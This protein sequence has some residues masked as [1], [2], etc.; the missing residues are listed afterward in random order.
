MIK[1]LNDYKEILD[2]LENIN[3]Q[4]VLNP[5]HKT[6]KVQDS[7]LNLFDTLYY[8]VSG[9]N[10]IKSNKN[11]ILDM[12]VFKKFLSQYRLVTIILRAIE[13]GASMQDFTLD[14]FMLL[15]NLKD[16][17]INIALASSKYI[18]DEIAQNLIMPI[19]KVL[20]NLLSNEV[21]SYKFKK[22]VLDFLCKDE[23]KKSKTLQ[24]LIVK[25][26]YYDE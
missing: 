25:Y 6:I 18:R 14:D 7:I 2:F 13:L 22:E 11:I 12:F 4:N 15:I 19:Y 20:D 21:L 24:P 23:N 16:K 17:D 10:D 1:L 26:K 9:V 3:N 8:I 5:L